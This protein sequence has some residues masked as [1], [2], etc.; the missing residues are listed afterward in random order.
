MNEN[1]AALDWATARGEKW[2]A[3]VV[4]ME[5]T[6]L[7][8][9]EPLLSAL[10][11]D[12]PF[13]VADVGCGGGGTAIETLRRAPAGSVVHG[14]DVSPALVE[15]ARGRVSPNERALAFDVADMAT[16][17]PERP[18]DRLV[19]R[20]GVMFFD[21][22]DAAFTNLVRWLNPG[23][24]F[25]FAVWGRLSDNHW[26]TSVHDIVAEVVDIPPQ[27]TKAPGPFRYGDS[28]EILRVLDRAGFAQLAVRDWRGAL[29]IGGGLP[30]AEAAHFALSSFSSFSELLAKAGDDAL[31]QARRSL[32]TCF[33][34]HQQDGAVR[35]EAC[36][37]IVTGAAAN[38]RS[39][40]DSENRHSSL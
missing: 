35:M 25:A 12:A 4:G 31:D 3:H 40:S 14:F 11:L 33:S 36:V 20:F 13:R 23:G 37:H 39:S 9:H 7:P 30:P 19:S 27:D 2:R 21:N 26:M 34:K 6:L 8:V 18:Y 22:P 32:T 38:T 15:V 5:S 16:A 10:T 17:A 29:P 24:L 1:P 28:D